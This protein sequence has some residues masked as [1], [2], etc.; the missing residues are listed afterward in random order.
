MLLT[1]LGARGAEVLRDGCAFVEGRW[2]GV[3]VRFGRFAFDEASR[4]LRGGARLV[5]LS[6]KAFELLALLI[7]E[8]PRA[9]AKAE[10]RDRLWP[11]TFVGET[12]L[13]RVVGE[14]RRALGECP[15]GASHVRTVQRFG[16]AFVAAA[17]DDA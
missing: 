7:R 17:T 16:Y 14:I 6:P 11:H 12:S 2:S 8:R 10:L 13:P 5:P 15:G 4:Q 9:F 1:N 3:S